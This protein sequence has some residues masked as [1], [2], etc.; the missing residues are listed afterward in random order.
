MSFTIQPI[1]LSSSKEINEFIDV[2]WDIYKN[3]KNWVPPL[4][5]ERKDHLD[6]KKNPFFAH[7]KVQLFVARDEKKKVIG[8]VSA[9]LN[10]EY[11]KVYTNGKTE[12]GFFGLYETPDNPEV[13][14]ALLD[15]A[16][17]WCKEQ[18]CTK[19]I[20]P[21][22]Y[23]INDECGLLVEGFDTPQYIF[24]AHNPKYYPGLIENNGYAKAKDL[25]AWHYPYF[26]NPAPEPALQMLEHVRSAPG[27]KIRNI[28]LN[29]SERDVKLMLEVFNSAWSQNWG[30]VPFTEA[31]SKKLAEDLKMFA[32]PNIIHLIEVEGKI[33]AVS[34]CL[35]NLHEVIKDLDGCRNPLNYAKLLYRV[36]TKK[37]T[38]MRLV[39][40]GVKKEFRG[41]V[42][43]G[44]ALSVALYSLAHQS[45][46]ANGYKTSELGWTLEDND[47]INKGIEL[48]GGVRYKLYRIY[49]KA[50]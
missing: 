19:I 25:I 36:K 15:A 45:C 41:G 44:G 47:K 46:A 23:S 24:M 13:A 40:L 14:K 4:V 11:D 7:A 50:L 49:E 18:G 21:M 22:S 17:K 2:Q 9:Q 29:Q 27:V 12:V 39:I 28:D 48:M 34:L 8:R 16:E 43:A 31:E 35:P 10:Y 33:A 32:D 38:Q 20:G 6:P 5:V 42:F 37:F 1:S 3:D 26:H 30:Y